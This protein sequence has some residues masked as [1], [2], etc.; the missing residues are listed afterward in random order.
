METS[1]YTIDEQIA[2]AI[3]YGQQLTAEGNQ[4]AGSGRKVQGD[5]AFKKAEVAACIIHSLMELK[6]IH[7]DSNAVLL[8][9]PVSTVSG[10]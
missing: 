9:S 5:A 6:E 7:N 4:W 8:S 2:S 1:Q 10:G 3:A